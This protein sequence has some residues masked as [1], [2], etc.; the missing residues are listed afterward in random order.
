MSQL[1]SDANL[2]LNQLHPTG[3]HYLTTIPDKKQHAAAHCT[4]A[5]DNCMYGKSASLGVE[6]MNRAS[7]LV[8]QKTVADSHN[9]DILLL[10]LEGK[11][12]NKWKAKAWEK[13]CH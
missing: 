8:P 5:P 4:V 6:A 3:S 12:Y 10:Q 11:R 7:K 1:E 2:Y 9:A 13:I